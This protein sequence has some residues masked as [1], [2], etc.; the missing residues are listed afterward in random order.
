MKVHNKL[1]YNTDEEHRKTKIEY[2]KKYKETNRKHLS[3]A[4]IAV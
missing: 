2:I 1:R 4:L 3:G